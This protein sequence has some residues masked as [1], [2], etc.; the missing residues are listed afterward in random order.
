MNHRIGWRAAR[1]RTRNTFTIATACF[2]AIIIVLA[3]SAPHGGFSQSG[4][5]SGDPQRG[6]E[7]FEKRCGGCHAL[8]K[9]KEGPRLGNVFGRKAGTISTFKYSDSLKS[10]Q[11]VWNEALLDKWLV[12]TDSVVP[13]NDMDF[14]LP[15]ADER[16]D[17]IQ[18]LRVS[19]G[20]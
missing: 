7:L 17:I 12:N 16:A 9:N 20:K 11:I 18:F 8:D 2:S 13:D 6:K 1:R 19:S 15:K 3:M 14:H 10:A 5:T 4:A